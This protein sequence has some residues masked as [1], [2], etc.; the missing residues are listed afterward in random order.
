M[1]YTLS[2]LCFPIKLGINLTNSEQTNQQLRTIAYLNAVK[3][4]KPSSRTGRKT[5]F[6]L[7]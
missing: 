4:F 7:L 2:I 1:K 5:V 6:K 3:T